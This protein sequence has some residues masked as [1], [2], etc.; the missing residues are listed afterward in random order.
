MRKT[1]AIMQPYFLPYIGY[2]QL[3]NLVDE[4][5]VYDNIQFTKKGWINRNRYLCE[6]KDK[7]FTIQIEKASDFLDICERQIAPTFE[8]QKL[9][10]QIRGTYQKAPYYEETFELFYN[11]VM[12]ESTNL[13]VFILFSINMIMQHLDITTPVIVSSQIEMDHS[14]KSLQRVLEICVKRQAN[15]YVNPIGGIELYDRSVFRDI[16]IEIEFL[17]PEIVPYKQT[18]AVFVPSL[19]IL[20]VLMFNGIEKTKGLLELYNLE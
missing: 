19:S 1:I 4:F 17:R 9:I 7:Y 15:H 8:R 13:F 14:L 16:G 10:N 2:W 6:G 18:C 5:I 3:I 11:I 12:F 20:D